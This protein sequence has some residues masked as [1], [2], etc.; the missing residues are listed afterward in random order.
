MAAKKQTEIL[1]IGGSAGSISVLLK[2]LPDLRRD[3]SFP[4]V[5]VLH[6]KAGNESG[7]ELLLNTHSNLPIMEAYDKI[8]IRPGTVYLAP[9]D[10]HLLFEDKEQIGLD[11][12]EKVNYSRPSIDVA[13]QSAA[14]VFKANTAALLLSGANNDGLKGMECVAQYGGML[15]L[16]DPATAEVAFMPKQ[17]LFRMNVQ[18]I[19]QPENMARFMNQLNGN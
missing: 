1:L 3:L 15:L 8:N 2:M 5:I 18:Q 6:R 10:Y 7:L 13:F 9:A 4:V 12:S 16:Q 17:V 14:R 11:F 19:L